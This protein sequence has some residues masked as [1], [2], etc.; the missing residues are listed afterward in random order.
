M[1]EEQG[2]G[3]DADVLARSSTASGSDSLSLRRGAVDLG[4]RHG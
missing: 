4:V 2:F 3:D 1:R